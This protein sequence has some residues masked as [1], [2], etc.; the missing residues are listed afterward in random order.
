MK[1]LA[2]RMH[3]N[4]NLNWHWNRKC[5]GSRS[6]TLVAMDSTDQGLLTCEVWNSHNEP[7]L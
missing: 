1:E 2:L 4:F 7:K 3:D 6:T 5:W